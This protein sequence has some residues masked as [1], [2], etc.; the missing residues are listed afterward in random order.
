MNTNTRKFKVKVLNLL[1]THF[2]NIFV[3]LISVASYI[4]SNKY[5][6]EK[7]V[8]GTK[9]E[10]ANQEQ[11][12]LRKGCSLINVKYFSNYF[13]NW[14]QIPEPKQIRNHFMILLF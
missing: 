12:V 11:G 2:S 14:N 9:D 7:F 6:S 5:I 13:Q 10:T 3:P 1:L 4:E 8:T